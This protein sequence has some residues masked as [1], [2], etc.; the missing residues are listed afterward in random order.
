MSACYFAIMRVLLYKL[1]ANE[2]ILAMLDF[3]RLTSQRCVIYPSI[4]ND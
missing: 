4:P 1:F 2:P 3:V